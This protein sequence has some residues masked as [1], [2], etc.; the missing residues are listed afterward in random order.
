M[1]E[2]AKLSRAEVLLF[3]HAD[4]HLPPDWKEHVA[5]AIAAPNVVGGAFRLRVDSD[6]RGLRTVE[7]L[8]NMR[9]LRLGIPYGDQALFVRRNIFE[10]VRGFPPIPILEDLELV[11]RLRARG[12]LVIARAY[13]LTSARRWKELGVL[14]TSL[15]NQ[16]M[17]LGRMFGCS[18]HD[19]RRV[20]RH[21]S[22]YPDLLREFL[23]SVLA[24]KTVAGR[25]TRGRFDAR[26]RHRG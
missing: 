15:T 13:V 18:P 14:R 12:K 22:S 26:S 24:A 21:A 9:S 17:L 7:R 10:E 1:N 8:A 5:E 3:L 11:L 16:L 19:L 25:S 6:L 23:R 2:G 4:T 20:Y